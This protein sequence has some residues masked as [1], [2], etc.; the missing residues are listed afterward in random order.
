MNFYSPSISLF[1]T[2]EYKISENNVGYYISFIS[3]GYLVGTIITTRIK[4]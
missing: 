2:K 1:L 4:G 3:I